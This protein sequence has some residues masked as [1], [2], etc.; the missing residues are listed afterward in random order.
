MLQDVLSLAMEHYFITLLLLYCIM[1]S[2]CCFG[3]SSDGKIEEYP[4]NVVVPVTSEKI[5]DDAVFS[6][7]E[8]G[9]LVIVDFY[10]SWCG[11]CR[12]ASPVFGKIS[13]GT[14]ISAYLIY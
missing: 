10:A 5:L 1:K 13:I 6:A 11:P 14:V 3:C 8:E 4:N 9:K 7:S 12:N 2:C